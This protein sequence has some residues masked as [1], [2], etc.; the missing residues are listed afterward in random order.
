MGLTESF[1]G[2]GTR[3]TTGYKFQLPTPR[4]PSAIIEICSDLAAYMLRSIRF[5]L[6]PSR[7]RNVGYA[8]MSKARTA[9][10]EMSTK[11]AFQRKES[12]YRDHIKEGTTFSPES[13][14]HDAWGVR[15]GCTPA[16]HAGRCVPARGPPPGH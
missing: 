3:R 5:A 15:H 2:T 10:E 8:T 14:A 12:L 6:P 1:G 13:E 11:G 9:L 16:S 4:F 7:T